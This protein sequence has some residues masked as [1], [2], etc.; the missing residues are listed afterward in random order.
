MARLKILFNSPQRF[1]PKAGQ[2]YLLHTTCG[3]IPVGVTSTNAFWGEAVMIHPYRALLHDKADTSYY[4]LVNTNTLLIPPTMIAKRDFR[5]QVCFSRVTDKQAPIPVPFEK[6]YNYRGSFAWNPE[7]L[8]FV[9]LADVL[10][11]DRLGSF[12]PLNERVIEYTVH[13]SNPPTGGEA[14]SVEPN[15]Y[16]MVDM[17]PHDVHLEFALEDALAYYEL[18][19]TPRP[20]HPDFPPEDE[21]TAEQTPM[22]DALHI[23][24]LDGTTTVFAAIDQLSGTT[25]ST[26]VDAGYQPNGYFFEGL[27]RYLISREMIDDSNIDFDSEHGLLSIIGDKLALT[28]IHSALST[29][30]DNPDA[31]RATIT[32][33]D[34]HNFDD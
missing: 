13:N 27:A 2:L 8:A 33:A 29:L 16:F 23:T 12:L 31:L 28:Q 19:D 1:R 34:A 26:V 7:E 20:A 5:K 25:L 11:R 4:P 32:E 14:T 10:P 17:V 6:Y 18:I 30:L 21:P 3:L 15:T 9:P 24:E 22:T